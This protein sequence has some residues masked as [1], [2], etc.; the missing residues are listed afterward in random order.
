MECKIETPRLEIEIGDITYEIEFGQVQIEITGNCNMN[1]QH[2]RASHQLKKDMPVEQIVKII[3]FARQFSPNYK[4]IIISGGEPLIHKN[5][6][7][8]LKQVRENGGESVTLTTNGSLLT[9]KHLKLIESLSFKRFQLS[10]SLDNLDSEK[11]DEFRK[12]N[13]AF[14][15]AVKSLQLIADSNIPNILSSMRSTI[16]AS[17]IREME[18]MVRFAKKLGC[19]RVSF[20][21]IHPSGKAI[22][23]EDLWMTQDQKLE[24]LKE[25]YRL[26]EVFPDINVTTNDPLKC[27]LRGK[28]DLGGKEN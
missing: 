11:H 26:K 5:F 25:I 8:V 19:K 28:N 15:K 1:C 23:R 22:K 10:I 12:H 18:E 3:K 13:G 20:S 27:L 24:F 14:Q 9:K 7:E 17:Q 16:Q 2:C 6:F 4:E 21:A